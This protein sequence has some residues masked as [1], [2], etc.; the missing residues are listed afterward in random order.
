MHPNYLN[1]SLKIVRKTLQRSVGATLSKLFTMASTGYLKLEQQRCCTLC[2]NMP[3]GARVA[4]ITPGIIS[5]SHCMHHIFQSLGLIQ[6]KL[7]NASIS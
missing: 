4:L 2:P 7:H 6:G 3:D 5:H 1:K